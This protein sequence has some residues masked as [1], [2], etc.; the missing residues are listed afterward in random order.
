MQD[1]EGVKGGR[2]N[3]KMLECG[4][5]DKQTAEKLSQTCRETKLPWFVGEKRTVADI[6]DTLC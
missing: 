4:D 5:R 6:T 1:W 2:L 3:V